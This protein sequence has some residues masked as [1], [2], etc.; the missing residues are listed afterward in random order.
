MGIV[1]VLLGAIGYSLLSRPATAEQRELYFPPASE[2]TPRDRPVVGNLGGLAVTFPPNFAELVS[3]EGDPGFGEKQV[4]SKP[5][6]THELGITGMR[7]DIRYPDFSVMSIK[8]RQADMR[9]Y[10]IYNTPWIGVGITASS[11]FGDGQFL[12][13]SVVHMNREPKFQ[14]ARLPEDQFG[15]EVYTPTTVDVSKRYRDPETGAFRSDVRDRDIFVHRDQDGRVDT[16][17][18]CSNRQLYSAPCQH[19]FYVGFP[20]KIE[21]R[22]GYRRGMLEHWKNIQSETKKVILSFKNS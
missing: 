2:L 21:M 11:H 10:T 17:I 19:F 6:R 1:A 8:E 9:K 13:R 16:L 3:Y 14:Y 5:K 4:G 20:L 15:L 22:V 18:Y 7:F 12:E